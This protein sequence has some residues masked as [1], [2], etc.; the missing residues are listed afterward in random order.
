MLYYLIPSFFQLLLLIK[1]AVPKTSVLFDFRYNLFIL[2][3]N[4]YLNPEKKFLNFIPDFVTIREPPCDVNLGTIEPINY[5]ANYMI[6]ERSPV[7]DVEINIKLQ[8][9]FTTN[10]NTNYT[11]YGKVVYGCTLVIAE[12]Q[13]TAAT[14][15]MDYYNNQKQCLAGYGEDIDFEQIK[16]VELYLDTPSQKDTVSAANPSKMVLLTP[17]KIVASSYL[18]GVKRIKAVTVK[19]A[20]FK[21]QQA[22]F[23]KVFETGNPHGSASLYF[24]KDT[25]DTAQ[26]S[27]ISKL[28]TRLR[29]LQVPLKAYVDSLK[30][31]NIV[32][33]ASRK[34]PSQTTTEKGS[35]S[36]TLVILE[37]EEGEHE[38]I[39]TASGQEVVTKKAR[40]TTK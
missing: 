7:I 9:F 8:R 18:T 32:F 13:A 2:E 4:R 29:P 11:G 15:L 35:K 1:V 12:K 21:L 33:E 24:H 20:S 19:D 16:M 36:P 26:P 25:V 5:P 28:E 10:S 22:G 27:E 39:V 3:Y 23:G 38:R 30:M 14:K 34:R 31:E 37:E 40:K 17:G 6:D